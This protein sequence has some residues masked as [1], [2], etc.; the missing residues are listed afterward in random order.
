MLRLAYKQIKRG[1][2][3]VIA[4][5]FVLAPLTNVANLHAA[6]TTVY[7]VTILLAQLLP[8]LLLMAQQR[9]PLLV[10]IYSELGANLL[11][12]PVLMATLPVSNPLA[13]QSLP[14]VT[15]CL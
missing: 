4:L 7:T 9:T 8:A 1:I 15:P 5:A 10:S 12:A 2:V 11:L 6:T 14:A 3:A 13:T